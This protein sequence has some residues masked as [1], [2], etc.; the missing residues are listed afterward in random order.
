MADNSARQAVD[1]VQRRLIRR[2]RILA[3]RL[4]LSGQGF[5]VRA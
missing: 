3:M 4:V 5:E 2:P 1:E